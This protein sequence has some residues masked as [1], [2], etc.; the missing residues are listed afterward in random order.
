KTYAEFAELH[1][2]SSSL[3]LLSSSSSVG[4]SS[5]SE[6]VEASSSSEELS[7]SS[8]EEESS[9]SSEILSSSSVEPSSSSEEASSSSIEASSSSVTLSSSSVKLAKCGDRPEE[10]DQDLY[11]CGANEII[12]LKNAVTYDGEAYLAVLIGDQTWMARNLN[13]NA[14]GSKCQSNCTTY[15]RMYNWATAMA[16]SADCNANTCTNQIQFPHRGIC[17]EGWHIPSDADWNLLFTVS[18]GTSTGGYKL[19]AKSGWNDYE[20]KSGNGTNDYGFSALP[21]GSIGTN[22]LPY[23]VGNFGN[24]WSASEYNNSNAYRLSIGYHS[25]N[26]N[27]YFSGKTTLFAIRCLQNQ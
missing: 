22:D 5:S 21:G 8:S 6:E 15:G 26:A 1:G 4:V 17:P 27:W 18:G 16:L 20:S 11:E 9:S 7:S 12:Y 3:L 10:F 13:Y 24:W 23:D 2:L 19:K 14:N 25:E